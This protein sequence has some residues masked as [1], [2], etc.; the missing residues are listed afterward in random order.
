MFIIEAQKMGL[1]VF[2]IACYLGGLLRLRRWAFGD[3]LPSPGR[4]VSSL[5]YVIGL[6]DYC[7]TNWN[8]NAPKL[9]KKRTPKRVEK[10]KILY[11]LWE[12]LDSQ[13]NFCKKLWDGSSITLQFQGILRMSFDCSQNYRSPSL[14]QYVV[15]LITPSTSFFQGTSIRG[16][17]DFLSF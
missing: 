9:G 13:D 16:D 1:P 4:F 6:C 8:R 10:F 14:C 3:I 5:I 7:S 17:I 15:W 11:I 12:G 2:P